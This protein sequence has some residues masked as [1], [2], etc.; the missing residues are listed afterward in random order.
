MGLQRGAETHPDWV[1]GPVGS[2][3]RRAGGGREAAS[4][5]QNQLVPSTLPPHGLGCVETTA[6]K[7]V[8]GHER[9]FS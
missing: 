6:E 8:C 3:G 7:A 9:R 5:D 4:P 1:G 2:G